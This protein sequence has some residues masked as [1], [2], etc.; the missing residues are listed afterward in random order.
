MEVRVKPNSS[1]T[2]FGFDSDVFYV[3][4]KSPPVEGRANAELLEQVSKLAGVPKTSLQLV[5][6]LT[7]KTKVVFCPLT[8]EA[9]LA[10]INEEISNH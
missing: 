6:G 3:R 5:S 7:S 2:G 4:L 9:L 10:R 1:K 8:V